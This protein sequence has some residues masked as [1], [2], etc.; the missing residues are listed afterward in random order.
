MTRTNSRFKGSPAD[1]SDVFAPVFYVLC[2]TTVLCVAMLAVRAFH[3]DSARFHFLLWNLFLAWL[4]LIVAMVAVGAARWMRGPALALAMLVLGGAWLLLYP[5]APYLTTDLIHLIGNPTYMWNAQQQSVLVW[6]DLVVFF[7][8]SWCGLLLGYL[9]MLHFHMLVR[10]FMGRF[11][12]W[13]FIVV[14][15]FLGG[16]GVYLGR[17]IRLNSWDVVFSPF[18]LIE[19]VRAGLDH[20]GAKFTLLFGMLILIVYLSLSSLRGLKSLRTGAENSRSV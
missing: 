14:V 10:R 17:M 4:P 18:R 9:S 19:G 15:S 2:G 8:F 16:F 20:R 3:L 5:N 7:L 1:D 6:Y 11:A 12:G 13:L